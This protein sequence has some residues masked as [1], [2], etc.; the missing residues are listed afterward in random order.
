ISQIGLHLAQYRH[1]TR[2]PEEYW[3]EAL[4][5]DAGDDLAMELCALYNQTGQHEHA[6][7]ILSGRRFQPWEGGEGQALGQHVRTHLAL[8]RHVLR[9]SGVDAAIRHF[10]LALESPENLGEARHLLANA[11]DV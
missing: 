9:R 7:R 8:G 1:A 10:K 11:S 4:R 5:R 2:M 6:L 3:R